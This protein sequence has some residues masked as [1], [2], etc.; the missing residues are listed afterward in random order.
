MGLIVDIAIIA[1]VLICIII[2]YVKGLTGC[3]LKIVSFVLS[4]I[5]AFVL[6]NPIANFVI[7]NTRWDEDLEEAI[8]QMA[9]AEN[10]EQSST[11]E[12]SNIESSNIEDS[13]IEDSNIEGSNNQEITNK[14][15]SSKAQNNSNGTSSESQ[16]NSSGT[17]NNSSG[18]PSVM[19]NYIN[20]AVE[21]AGDEAKQNI[22]DVAAK[23]VAQ[24]I[25]KGGVLI[26][27]FIVTRLLLMVIKVLAKFITEIPLIKQIDKTGGVIYGILQSLVIIY[28]IL[29]IISFVSPM[30]T[31]TS[32]VNAIQESYIGSI[33]Y[34]NN[35]LLKLLF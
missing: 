18:I 24:T 13:N 21:K 20:D 32:I 17:K 26:S 35:L 16:N 27:L 6:F 4:I 23:D 33:L 14:E 2:G 31:N 8:R 28:V 1:I 9:V 5:V 25:I 29:A 11:G 15:T 3:L 12:N 7:D 34:N 30:I 10:N 22:V 19:M